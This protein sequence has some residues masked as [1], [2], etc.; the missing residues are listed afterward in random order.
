M[1]NKWVNVAVV[2][3]GRIYQD[4]HR[5]GYASRYSTN[6][7]V[8]GLC[9]LD[10]KRGKEE[11]KWLKKE[12]ERRLKK[13]EK[14]EPEDAERIKFGLQYLD[15]YTDYDKML[16]K[17]E[18][19]LEFVDNCTE[20]R[21][22]VPLAVK[23]MEHGYHA[24]SEKPPA[25]N[26]WDAKR[27]VE[28]E[29][30]TGKFFA[31]AEN[32]CYERSSLKARE[33]VTGGKIGTIEEIALQFGHGGP[34]VPY[35]LGPTGLPHFIDPIMSGGG[36]LQDLAPHG[37][38][39]ALWPLGPNVRVVACETRKVER[40]KNPREMS[41]KKFTSPVDDWV[42]A[43]LEMHDPRTNSNFFM[44][45]TTSWCGGFSF[46]FTITTDKGDFTIAKNP[47]G[48]TYDPVLYPEDGEPTFFPVDDDPW[49]PHESH[50]REIQMFCDNILKNQPAITP[51]T[52]ALHLQEVLSIQY[53]SKLK[54]KRV[55]LEE[56][57]QFGQEI[58]K[59]YSDYQQ[60]VNNIS[61]E[62]IK[63]VDLL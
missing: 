27:L 5:H 24:M 40:R 1:A 46:P 13:A 55:T 53:L 33:V 25:L 63:S 23:A 6:N 10:E 31:L 18:G 41:G 2:G 3:T 32:V 52:Y 51:A 62:L 42:E 11:L 47:K 8:V 59:N 49:E 45:V 37:I 56:M 44:D 39:R 38:S 16:D 57:E 19:T 29:K 36:T 61:L 15:F 22:H 26:W 58:A 7:V 34:Y 14:K 17:L 48:K 20:G 54:K 4:A 9:D 30:K 50:I 60:Q 28:A 12:Y 35:V 21:G 43:K